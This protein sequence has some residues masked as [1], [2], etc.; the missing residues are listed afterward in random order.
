MNGA[1]GLSVTVT[2]SEAMRRVM[3]PNPPHPMPVAHREPYAPY[4]TKYTGLSRPQRVSSGK[5]AK[6][7]TTQTS[8][9]T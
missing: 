6:L 1:P 4:A 5:S 2:N 8:S 7:I 3:A 9:V